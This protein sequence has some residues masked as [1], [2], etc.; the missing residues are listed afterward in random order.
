[1]EGAAFFMTT[2]KVGR[3]IVYKKVAGGDEAR[4]GVISSSL[5]KL[6]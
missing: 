2:R 5:L 6:L 1:M 4:K 3:M